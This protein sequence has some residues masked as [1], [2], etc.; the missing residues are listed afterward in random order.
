MA[1]P[2][3]SLAS[4]ARRSGR[5][6]G[7]AAEPGPLEADGQFADL[8]RQQCAILT[9]ENA[10]KWN[11]LRPS[12]DRYDFRDADRLAAFASAAGLAMHGHGLVWH[13][14]L[15]AWF[16][17][18]VDASNARRLLGEH[19]GAVVGR[20]AG[21]IRSWDVNEAVERNDHRAD[22]L[23]RSPWLELVGPDYLDFSFRAAHAA[24]PRAILTLADYGLEYD[25]VS[26]MVEKRET[27][28]ELLAGMKQRGVPIHALALQGH[29]DGARPPAFGDG[30]SRFFEAVARLG[31]KIFVT[32]LDVDDQALGGDVAERDAVVAN[33]YRGFLTTILRQPAVRMVVTWG[34]S[35]R[36]TSKSTFSP[37]P[38]GSPVR[39]LP[40]DRSLAPK[41]ASLAMVTA[42]D[43][44][45]P[46]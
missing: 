38:D 21:F 46:A 28:L 7:A 1:K 11:A 23:R 20:Y 29:L 10:L 16:D 22:G 27:M 37:R 32:E 12:I 18:A 33:V 5:L 39:P 19:I 45:T 34:L 41:P 25:D 17:G 35:D 42:F 3:R 6:Y 8:F 40:F 30:L 9:A 36:Y 24:D 13:E 2:P 43:A 15:P 4:A 44:A 31:L 14:A 26:W